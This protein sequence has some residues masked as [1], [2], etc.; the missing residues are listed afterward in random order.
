ML[1]IG[2]LGVAGALLA[3]QFKGGKSEYGMYIGVGVSLFIFF[4]I[5]SQMEIFTDTIRQISSYMNLET[6]YITIL[7]KIL[8]I[9]YVAEFASG[10]C[11]DA[12][13]QTIASQIEIFGKLAVLG[14]GVPV[15]TTLLDTIKEFLS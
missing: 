14:L 2:I 3:I 1:E 15:L 9:T 5:L 8:G 11:K 6:V 7:L 4:G 12:G 13:Y 10:I